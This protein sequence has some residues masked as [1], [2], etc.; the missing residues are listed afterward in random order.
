MYVYINNSHHIGGNMAEILKAK[1]IVESSIEELKTQCEK[2]YHKIGRVPFMKVV[3]VGDNPASHSYIKNKQKLCEK[4]GAKFELVHLEEKVSEESFLKEVRNLNE[5]QNVD[6]FI[7]QM[8]VPEQLKHLN[9]ENLVDE[10]KDIDGF[11]FKNVFNLYAG[12]NKEDDLLP[13][14]PKGVVQALDYYKI[15]IEGKRV[16]IIGRSLIVGKPLFHLLTNRNATVT[17]CHSRTPN[18]EEITSSSDIIITALGQA[19]FLTKA[20]I[21]GNKPVIIDVGIN[22]HE[23]KL[24][25]DCKF[26]E[27]EKITS[28]ITPVPGGIGPLTVLN[29]IKNLFIATQRKI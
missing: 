1:P 29:L 19:N 10:N 15:P 4:V 16:A 26:G 27:L 8:P 6:G 20:H 2:I 14:T 11:N 22:K 5:N 25:G 7:I 17:L 9:L 12:K 18:I 3:L 28:A 24:C 23:G 21:G 13:C